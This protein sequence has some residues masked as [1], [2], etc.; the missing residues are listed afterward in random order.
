MKKLQCNNLWRE[1]TD[2]EAL[3][4]WLLKGVK[5]FFLAPFLFLNGYRTH[6]K[7]GERL[8]SSSHCPI[9]IEIKSYFET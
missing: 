5:T 9:V 4:R 7:I 8:P 2:G 6:L 3:Y 1:A